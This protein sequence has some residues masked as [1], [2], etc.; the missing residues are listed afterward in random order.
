[1]MLF[2]LQFAVV[3][4]AQCKQKFNMRQRYW[5]TRNKILGLKA[6]ASV[7][8]IVRRPKESK[9]K[10]LRQLSE[11][12]IKCYIFPVQSLALVMETTPQQQ[13]E[14]KLTNVAG[15]LP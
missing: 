2:S 4:I 10:Q 8:M 14:K 15:S 6:S 11:S 12:N 5:Q 9:P 13:S 7:I 3:S 1:M